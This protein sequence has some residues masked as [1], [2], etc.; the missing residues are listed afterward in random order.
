LWFYKWN[1]VFL[2]IKYKD[3]NGDW[4]WFDNGTELDFGASTN[5]R[6]LVMQTNAG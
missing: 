6:Y 5:D 1:K 4:L 3:G 2:I